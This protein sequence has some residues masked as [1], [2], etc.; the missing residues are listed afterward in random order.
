MLLARAESRSRDPVGLRAFFQPLDQLGQCLL[1]AEVDPGRIAPVGIELGRQRDLV[2]P[3]ARPRHGADLFDRV[4]DEAFYRHIRIADPV[5]EGRVGAV[6]QQAPNQVG[7]QRLVR[8]NR[9]IDP[10]RP[11]EPVWAD[12]LFVKRFA[13][14]VQ[15]LEFIL[16][17]RIVR[18]RQVMDRR[19]RLGIVGG[20]LREHRVGRGQQLAGAGDIGDVGVD[21][22]GIDREVL[23]PVHLRALDLGVPIGALDQPD[24]DPPPGPARQI[25]DPVDHRRAALAIGLDDEAQAVPAAKV[26]IER[27]AFE[28]VE[29]QLEPVHFLGIDVEADVVALGQYRQPVHPGQQLAHNPIGLGARIARVQRRQL[30]RDARALDD[31]ASGRSLADRVDRGL[32]IGEIACRIGG[33]GRRLAKHVIAVAKPPGFEAAGAIERLF[34]SLAGDELFAHQP[35]RQVHALADHRLASAGH[36]PGQG[37]GQA[38]IVDAANQLAGDHQPPGRGIDEQRTPAAHVRTP[39]AIGDLV[40]DKRIAGRRVGDP[41]QRFGQAHQR[42]PFVARQRIFL[43]QSFDPADPGIG[44]QSGDECSGGFAH[45]PLHRFGQGRLIEQ[46]AQALFLAAPVH[47]G[48]GLAQQRLLTDRRGETGEGGG[49]GHGMDNTRAAD[50]DQTLFSP[51]AV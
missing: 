30:D 31:P 17:G 20:E 27:Q 49:L 12:D 36:Q 45:R 22:A 23:Q 15:A 26:R 33:S 28:Q 13:H 46:D 2:V 48:D 9:G 47:R 16:R 44:A 41:Q 19:Q 10:A 50:G 43:N 11:V 29:R 24:H 18:S 34:D 40:A 1:V 35:H 51:S 21:L 38:G 32:V 25:D 14:S 42:D 8:A 7:E 37:G 3:R 4:G 39:V 6:L 5:D